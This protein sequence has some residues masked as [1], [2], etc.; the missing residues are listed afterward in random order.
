MNV[1]G[2]IDLSG[3]QYDGI[4]HGRSPGGPGVVNQIGQVLN[5]N[6]YKQKIGE[7]AG[8]PLSK[9]QQIL[10]NKVVFYQ[11]K[12]NQMYQGFSASA[13]FRNRSTV[14]SHYATTPGSFFHV[15]N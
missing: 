12:R 9:K 7:V 10:T 6:V 5:S 15:R 14:E 2:N 3:T 1:G 13:K 4:N 8:S 11:A